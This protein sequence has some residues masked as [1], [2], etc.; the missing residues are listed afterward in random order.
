MRTKGT[1]VVVEKVAEITTE[2]FG[3]LRNALQGI[4]LLMIAALPSISHA[5]QPDAPFLA[6]QKKHADKWAK[7]DKVINEKL[8]A[9]EKKF[10]KKPNIIYIL[11]DDIGFGELGWQ[12]GA[13]IEA[14]RRLRWTRWPTRVCASFGLTPSRPAHPVALQSI[15]GVTRCAPA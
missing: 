6:S 14:P 10:G 12:G 1:P 3:V 13:S 15:R 4:A 7:E 5:I 9:L 8:A 2:P 11:A